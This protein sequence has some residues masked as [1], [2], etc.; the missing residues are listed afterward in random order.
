M[1]TWSY[2]VMTVPSRRKELLP[3]TL[4][5]LQKGGFDIPRLFVEDSSDIEGYQNQFKCPVTVRTTQL[6]K[7]P[8][9]SGNWVLA[10]YE[11]FVRNPNADRYAIFQDDLVT[12]RNLRQYLETWETSDVSYWNLYTFP[13]NVEHIEKREGN[14]PP[15]NGWH[16]S[17]QFGRGAVGLVFSKEVTIKL[18]G[19]EYIVRRFLDEKRG[20]L[21]I[22]G[23]IIS[24]LSKLSIKEMVHYPSLLYHTGRDSSV[25]HMEQKQATSFPG[26]IY[27]AMELLNQSKSIQSSLKQKGGLGDLV[28]TALS[29]VGV[30]KEVVEAWVGKECGCRERKEKLNQLTFWARRV[31]SGI[32]D[33]AEEH[34]NNILGT[35]KL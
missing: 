16:L 2:G 25:G 13:S 20:H 5:S 17:N 32:K 28:E 23:G 6:H 21:S 35:K 34:L 7:L 1:I 19:S 12:I 31:M 26:E 9:P 33:K 10:L 15:T 24:T 30:T 3:R 22:D 29:S 27:D 11:L 18:L 4:Y 8:G 14:K